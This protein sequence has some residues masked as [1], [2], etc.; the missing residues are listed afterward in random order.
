MPNKIKQ[1]V[2]K[3]ETTIMQKYQNI[4]IWVQHP[5]DNITKEFLILK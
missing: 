1:I 5:N 4:T 3:S 2:K